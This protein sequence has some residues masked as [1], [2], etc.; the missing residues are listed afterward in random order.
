MFR[1]PRAVFE[2]ISYDRPI[3]FKTSLIDN[4][5]E[6]HAGVMTT[7]T[8]ATTTSLRGEV[9]YISELE[10]SGE[11]EKTRHVKLNQLLATSIC[12]NDITSSCL[13]VSAICALYAG[14]YAPLSLLLVAGVLYL[15]RKVY[16]EVGT[17]LPL[18][19]GA[20]NV[21]LNTTSKKFA[22]LAACLTIL[23]YIATAV[24]SAYEAMHY[25]HQIWHEMSVIPATILLLCL[26]AFLS[27]LG[28]S[29]SAKVATGIFLFHITTLLL[30]VGA[31]AVV[32]FQDTSRLMA[33]FQQ[34]PAIGVGPAVF[35]GFAA[36]MLGVSG[37]ESSAN[38]IEEQA[39]GV[40]VKTLRN[41]WVAVAFF[42]PVISFLSLGILSLNDIEAHKETL[43]AHMGRESAMPILGH[44]VSI[45]AVL[46]LSGA[47]ITSFVGVSGLVRRMSLDRCLP[48]FLLAENR[49]RGTNHWIFLGFLGLC[50][51][52]LLATHG[53]VEALAGVYTISFLSVMALFALGNMLMKIKRE[54]LRRDERASWPSVTLALTAV[55]TGLIG[56][57]LLNPEHVI[58][59]LL[60]FSLTILVVGIMFTRLSLLRA[61]MFIFQSI[62][63]SIKTTN[64][65]VLLKLQNWVDAI[66]SL[67]VI[68]FSRGDNLA[69]LNRAALYVL[70]NENLKRLEIVHV[71]QKEEDIPESLRE[72]VDIVDREYPEL[73]VDLILVQ[74]TFGPALVEALSQRL[75]VPQNYM[76]IGTPGE[77]FPHDLGA[78]GGVRLII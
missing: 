42:N 7:G 55:V 6:V 67:T 14:P 44:L 40:F 34:P 17:A 77:Q 74:G 45:D 68:Y 12:G 16:G 48:Q 5:P 64:D 52:I 75:Q 59:F 37:F 62:A 65:R 47:V 27:I 41:M 28:I 10:T 23:S 20:Y 36:A 58:V 54:R 50:V 70:G 78:L 8:I 22:S 9:R 25:A 1:A 38:F 43:L 29:E 2:T 19:G 66:N 46:V 76:F 15:F 24:I 61:V 33:N 3:L 26:F 51:S 53:E 49:W 73:A 69:N 32:V 60:Y 30:L 39:D 31:C 35:F 71:Y 57:V 21:L 18:N 63:G 11:A 4:G 13:Y 56:N 72:H